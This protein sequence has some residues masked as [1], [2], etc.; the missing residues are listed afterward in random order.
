MDHVLANKAVFKGT[1]DAIGT[2]AMVGGGVLAATQRGDAQLVG[3]GLLAA[4]LVSKIVSSA[5]TPAADTRSWD[6]LPQY[7]SFTSME[8][9]PG[10]Y[11]GAVDFT[12][13]AGNVVMTKTFKFTTPAPNGHDAVIFLS[14]KSS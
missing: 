7:L 8:L 6:N 4:G 9:P 14:D 13:P 1:T 12:D 11:D 10:A 3:V 5:T 2:G